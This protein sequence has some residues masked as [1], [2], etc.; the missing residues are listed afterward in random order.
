M[1]PRLGLLL[2]SSAASGVGLWGHIPP[3]GWRCPLS[4]ASAQRRP[5]GLLFPRP[6][7]HAPGT[8]AHLAGGEV[9]VH[10]DGVGGV[11]EDVGH[12][13]QVFDGLQLQ[14]QQVP[15]EGLPA[16]GLWEGE[17]SGAGAVGRRGAAA[18]LRSLWWPCLFP[19]LALRPG[20]PEQPGRR[21]LTS[22]MGKLRP[23][24]PPRQVDSAGPEHRPAAGWPGPI[25]AVGPW[26]V[27][28]LPEPQ[29]LHLRKG[30]SRRV[31][32]VGRQRGLNSHLHVA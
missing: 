17:L 10:G 31:P 13:D 12:A 20:R 23:R 26:R 11:H 22:R 16:D 14:A 21:A 27:T 15:V 8:A 24:D 18:L 25:L 28:D 9:E 1:K 6:P 7:P 5:R 2:Q 29:R 30:N 19:P 32:S 4:A 3:K